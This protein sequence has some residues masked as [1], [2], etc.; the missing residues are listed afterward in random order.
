LSL[1]FFAFYFFAVFGFFDFFFAFAI[2]SGAIIS[3][4]KNRLN[5]LERLRGASAP[6]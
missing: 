6:P 2:V 4:K 1:P 3:L 5:V